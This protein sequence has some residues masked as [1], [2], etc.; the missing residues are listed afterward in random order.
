MAMEWSATTWIVASQGVRPAQ[1]R[2]RGIHTDY[3][4]N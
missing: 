2:L 4:T 3:G 1:V